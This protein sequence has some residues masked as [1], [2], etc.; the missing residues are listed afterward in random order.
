MNQRKTLFNNNGRL[1]VGGMDCEDIVKE[2]HSPIYV[3]DQ[4]HIED[5]C[6]TFTDSLS[7]SYGDGMISYASKAFCCK[8]IYRIISKFNMGA[9]VVSLGELFTAK[10]AKVQPLA[11]SLVP[12]YTAITSGVS[13]SLLCSWVALVLPYTQTLSPEKEL[14]TNTS[15]PVVSATRFHQVWSTLITSLLLP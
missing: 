8:E 1:F 12:K 4:K 6:K 11:K 2:F 7:E 10:S 14:F 15:I 9:D 13:P 3:F 5:V